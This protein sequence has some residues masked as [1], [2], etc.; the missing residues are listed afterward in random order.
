MTDASPRRTRRAAAAALV[1]ITIGMPGAGIP[2]EARGDEPAPAVLTAPHVLPTLAGGTTAGPLVVAHGG[3]GSGPEYA[4]GPRAAAD[5]A[6]GVLRGHGSALDAALAGTVWLENDP[7]FNAG[8]GANIRLDGSTIQMDAALMTDEGRFAAVGAIERVKNPVLVARAV[9]DSTPHLFLVGEGATRFAH[10]VGFADILPVSPQAEAKF[11][12][13]M[14]R[15]A[16]VFGRR[17]TTVFDWRRYW[18]FPGPL[19]ADA[20]EWGKRG[21]TVGSVARSADGHFAAT[22]STGGTSVTLCGR[23]GDVPVYGAGLYAGPA[24]AVACTGEGEQI[25]KRFLAHAVYERMASGV[26]ARKSVE[27]EVAMF[28]ERWDVGVIAVD[29]TGW[30]VAANRPMAYGVAE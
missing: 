3:V 28:P 4:D 8:T 18:N 27:E 12:A 25:I 21:D 6:L 11:R 13:R 14:K 17:D 24:G 29:R 16:E 9:M 1:L 30:G 5:T 19:P 26:P 20:L 10:R 15:Q 7:R 2:A 23:V 22:L